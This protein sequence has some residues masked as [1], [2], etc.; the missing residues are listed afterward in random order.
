MPTT[1]A[2]VR[3]RKKPSR[4]RLASPAKAAKIPEAPKDG[5]VYAEPLAHRRRHH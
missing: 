1:Q 3:D 2:K 5:F 4:A